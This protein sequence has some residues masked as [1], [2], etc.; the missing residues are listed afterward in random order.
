MLP[1]ILEFNR[2]TVQVIKTATYQLL[3]PRQAYIV[4]ECNS[5]QNKYFIPPGCDAVPLG[6]WCQCR[7]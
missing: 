4:K 6:K 3:E 1:K 5:F 7:P 2:K